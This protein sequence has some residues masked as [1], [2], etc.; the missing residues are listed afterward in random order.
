M[1]DINDNPPEL[2]PSPT[3]LRL[4]PFQNTEKEV[5]FTINITDHDDWAVGH[6]PPFRIGA[7]KTL[8]NDASEKEKSPLQ[9]NFKMRELYSSSCK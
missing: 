7:K 3:Y 6:G 8:L 5:T 4:P 2:A 1:E 9:I